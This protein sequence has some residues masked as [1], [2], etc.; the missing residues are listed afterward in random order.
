MPACTSLSLIKK[1]PL[2]VTGTETAL[3]LGVLAQA[4]KERAVF[5]QRYLWARRSVRICP[6]RAENEDQLW[7]ATGDFLQDRLLLESDRVCQEDIKSI[8]KVEGSVAVGIFK[9]EVLV[10]F[11]SSE[12]RDTVMMSAKNLAGNVDA[13]GLPLA[14]VKLE[15]PREL[16]DT[17][18]HG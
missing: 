11:Y 5:S 13:S 2:Q 1:A 12:V 9:N 15:I 18:R 6:L 8:E 7:E 17:S 3:S 10:T 14:G 16:I 4:P